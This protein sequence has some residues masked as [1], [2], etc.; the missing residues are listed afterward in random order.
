MPE[1]RFGWMRERKQTVIAGMSRTKQSHKEECD[2]NTIMRKFYKTGLVKHVNR[3]QGDYSAMP[4]IEDYQ[5]ALSIQ[6]QARDA[7]A[8]LPAKLRAE[9]ENDPGLFLRFVMNPENKQR[10]KELGLLKK[11]DETAVAAPVV[12]ES[13]PT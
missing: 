5:Q 8:S 13:A 7:F 11:V 4:D 12:V 10:M 3:F 6:M 9:F 1:I 2:I